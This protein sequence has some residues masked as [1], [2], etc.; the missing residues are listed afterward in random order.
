VDDTFGVSGIQGIRDL[1]G[2]REQRFNAEAACASLIGQ[3]ISHY[4]RHN[5]FDLPH[6]AT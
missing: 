1:D 5:S 3:T 6:V 2:Y 4:R